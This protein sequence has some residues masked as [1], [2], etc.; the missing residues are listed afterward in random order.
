MTKKEDMMKLS[1]EERIA[2]RIGLSKTL[3]LIFLLS[4]FIIPQIPFKGF[5]KL[6]TFKIDSGYTRILSFNYDQDEYSDLL[7]YN[8]LDKKA[9]IYRGNS[10]LNFEFNKEIDFPFQP[11]RFE[12]IIAQNKMI[13]SYAFTSRKSRSFGIYKFTN[14]GNLEL[15][16]HIK[17]NSY[18]ENISIADLGNDGKPEFLLSGNAFE[19]LSIIE[20]KD[21]KLKENK[22]LGK[23][24]FLNAQFIDLNGDGIKDIVTLN[25][26]DNKLHFLF[27]NGRAE[28]TELR[29]IN[30]NENV[31]ALHVFDFNYDS[32]PDIIIST[33]SSIKIYF[34]DA[35]NSYQNI[36]SIETPFNCN[37]FIIGDFNRDGYFDFNCLSRSDGEIFTIF[38]KNFYSFYKEIVH[39]KNDGIVDI[40]P[41]FSKFVYGSAFINK[42]GE[43]SILSKIISLSDDQNLALGVAPNVISKFD[44]NDNGINDLI[45]I[46]NNDQ[47]LKF[48]I[49]DAAG[50]PD[51][52]YSVSLSDNYNSIIDFSN[53]KFI[54]TFFCFSLNKRSV[55]SVE[56]NFSNFTFK[57][58]YLY[59]NGPIEDLLI[60]PDEG[61]KA[62]VF[63]LYS[64]YM[65]LNFEIFSQTS[66]KYSSRT[67]N[68]ISYNWFSP[69]IISAKEM[70]IGFW[71][72]NN[73]VT[74]FNLAN[75]KGSKFE[76]KE[77][78]QIKSG[79]FD[80]ISKSDVSQSR[81]DFSFLSLI[82]GTNRISLLDASFNIYFPLNSKY[83]FRI[84]NKNQLFFDKTNSIFVN[85]KTDRAFYKLSPVKVKNQLKIEKIFD[86]IDISNFIVTNLD[87]RNF[88]IVYTNNN[89]IRIR[90]LPK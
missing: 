10:G 82:S 3:L 30:I 31:L 9:K 26:V 36:D 52:L 38:A 86:G 78:N 18:P 28:F 22:I 2:L 63:V 88:H 76:I 89:L 87:Q 84:T 8:P 64:K 56:V 5:C 27:N 75:L 11:S 6:T 58:K 13:E 77:T 32:Y 14:Q 73:W 57:H 35:T 71:Y 17:F 19:G 74:G 48:I 67:Y 41:F 20:Q 44:L 37:D 68:D 90:Q 16:N 81:S 53:S 12:P 80:I 83:A 39:T 51:K 85:D 40:I 23:G 49:R 21:N 1:Q 33:T 29:E 72:K 7:I 43:V 79:E 50:F 60:S 25:S 66:L 59:A 61:G 24:T 55:E 69:V 4:D 34:G 54:K 62:E 70:L 42:S 15:I 45:F 65:S 46:D 47:S